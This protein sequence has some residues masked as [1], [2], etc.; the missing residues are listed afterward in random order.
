MCDAISNLKFWYQS[1][2]RFRPGRQLK[3][4]ISLVKRLFQQVEHCLHQ[5]PSEYFFFHSVYLQFCSYVNTNQLKQFLR[6]FGGQKSLFFYKCVVY[7]IKCT[8]HC[9]LILFSLIPDICG[10]MIV[11]LG[12]RYL[13]LHWSLCPASVLFD[14]CNR[15]SY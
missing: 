5:D 14:C 1:S 6:N 10:L 3:Q 7:M 13:H 4:R 2:L 12:A 9:C 8:G 11:Y 15:A